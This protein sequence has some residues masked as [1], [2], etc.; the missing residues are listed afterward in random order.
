MKI[1]FIGGGSRF[2]G[3]EQ[4][5]L[6]LERG[7]QKQ[8]VTCAHVVSGWSD[9]LFARHLADNGI[10]A[11]PIK[12]GRFYVRRPL[13]TLDTL[14]ELPKAIVQLRAIVRSFAP[15]VIV[16]LDNRSF[17]TAYPILWDFKGAHIYRESVTPSATSRLD[18]LTYRAIFSACS[19]VIVNSDDTAAAFERG[20]Y[21]KERVALVRNGVDCERI[22]PHNRHTGQPVRLGIVGQ[23]IPRK[24]HDILFDALARLRQRGLAFQLVIIG[25][26]DAGFERSVRAQ[27]SSL[28]LDPLITWA[29]VIY[30][31]TAIYGQI[32]VLVVPSRSESF[33]N[34]TI[35]AGAAGLPVVA[36]R[37]GG[38]QDVIAD[39]ETGTLVDP[40]A[41]EALAD[42]LEAL[43]RDPALRARMGEAARRRVETRFSAERWARDFVQEIE[44]R[45]EF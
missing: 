29:G 4:A 32:D 3:M 21:P 26:G 28:Q 37:V 25:E 35:E 20:G 30:D 23:V 36:S 6:T 22:R 39:G 16:H 44:R 13:W 9:G 19:C 34:V 43:I 38:L 42:A 14:R 45:H 18:A 1:L 24:G 7:L 5:L 33:G 41:S 12:L 2:W 8:G 40:E 17:M 15:D 11:F 27:A 10:L 31:K